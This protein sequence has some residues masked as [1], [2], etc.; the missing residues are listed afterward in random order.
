MGRKLGQHFL[1][2]PA[3]LDR[4]V[5]A[6]D[7]LPTD[8]VLEIGPGKGTLTRR[9]AGRVGLVVAVEKD[10]GLARQLNSEC[11]VEGTDTVQVSVVHGDAL[12]VDW[13]Q[14][15]AE[16]AENSVPST[17]YSPY[18][19]I[20]NIPYYI[21]SPLIDK[22][23]TPPLPERIVFLMQKEV[24]DRLSAEPGTKTYGALSVGVQA[25]ADAERLFTVKRGAFSPPPA[26]DSAVVRLK[27]KDEPL[28]TPEEQPRF[29]TFVQ[30]MFSRRRKQIVGIVRAV[31]SLPPDRALEALARVQVDPQ[32]RPETLAPETVV[33]LYRALQSAG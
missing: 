4:I 19:V 13:G 25:V 2:D 31:A 26:V 33:R 22:A 20:G 29:R 21:T 30:A 14:L 3:I 11:R 6:L 1:T 28:V 9:L 5:D 15:V 7:P 18:K 32:A 12:R 17:Q 10:A 8:L 27:P 23:L 16:Q 24:A